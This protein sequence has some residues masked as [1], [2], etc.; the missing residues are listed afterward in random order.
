[1]SG[2]MGLLAACLGPKP[3]FVSF[4]EAENGGGTTLTINKPAGV[5]SG[6]LLVACMISNDNVPC[7][8]SGDAGWTERGDQGAVP[9]L[10]I[11]TKVAGGAEG[12]SYTFTASVAGTLSGGIFAFQ[13]AAYDGLGSY[14]TIIT[15]DGSVVAPSFVMSNVGLLLAIY[16]TDGEDD[17]FGTPSGMTVLAHI[18]G[19]L[20]G[21]L[22]VFAQE[23]NSGGSGARTATIDTG[24]SDQSVGILLGIVT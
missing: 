4:E 17:P 8:W 14:G 15:G 21:S 24:F 13:Q 5:V 7:S 22:S 18:E 20:G 12:A 19:G 10:R 9:N 1:M 2:I 23:V 6:M 11:A 3:Q 16:G